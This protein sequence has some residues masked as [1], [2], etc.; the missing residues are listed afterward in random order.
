MTNETGPQID[1]PDDPDSDRLESS[2]LDIDIEGASSPP[3][4]SM[5]SRQQKRDSKLQFSGSRP[6]GLV[7]SLSGG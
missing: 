1:R 7:L 3:A 4:S 6:K 2:E 5:S